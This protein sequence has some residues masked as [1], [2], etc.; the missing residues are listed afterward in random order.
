M[1][2]MVLLLI[3][4]LSFLSVVSILFSFIVSDRRI[5]KRIDYYLKIEKDKIDGIEEKT[6]QAIEKL[7]EYRTALITAAV[8]GKIDVRH[9]TVPKEI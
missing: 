8:T 6:Q 1:K 5:K 4:L 2:A 3:F 9:Y 7:E